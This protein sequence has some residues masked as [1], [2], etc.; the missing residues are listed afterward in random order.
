VE[1]FCF[2]IVQTQPRNQ[3]NLKEEMFGG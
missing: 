3:L 1:Y 2:R